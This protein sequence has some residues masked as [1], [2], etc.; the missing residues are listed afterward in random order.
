M[1]APTSHAAATAAQTMM[2]SGPAGLTGLSG[3]LDVVETERRR[4]AANARR[5]PP[6]SS[7]SPEPSSASGTLRDRRTCGENGAS[8]G[9]R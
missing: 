4:Q 5:T 3:L 2:M 1:P 9:T 6:P 8:V 7:M